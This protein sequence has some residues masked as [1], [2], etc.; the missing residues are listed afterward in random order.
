MHK[1][2]LSKDK[3]ESSLEKLEIIIKMLT[4]IINTTKKNMK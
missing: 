2:I 1:Y 4:K 3:A